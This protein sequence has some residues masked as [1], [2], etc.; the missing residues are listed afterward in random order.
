M[1]TIFEVLT[2]DHDKQRALMKALV[3]TEGESKTR[4]E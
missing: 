1:T 4:A 2:E 3:E